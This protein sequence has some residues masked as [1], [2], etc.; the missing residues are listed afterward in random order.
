LNS[1]NSKQFIKIVSQ[2]SK[3]QYLQGRIEKSILLALWVD[4]AMALLERYMTTLN[5]LDQEIDSVKRGVLIEALEAYFMSSIILYHR[6]FVDQPSMHLEIKKVTQDVNLRK[7]YQEI[8]KLRNDEFIHWKGIRSAILVKYS[9]EP[10]SQVEVKFAENI[11]AQFKDS[12]GPGIDVI[13]FKNLYQETAKYIERK[14]IETL[15]TL[16]KCLGKEEVFEKCQFL[17]DINESVI[18]KAIK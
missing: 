17:N 8:E 3:V 10:V 2:D 6:C 15:D 16:R 12:I 5:H 7:T 1:A 9:F 14:R 13:P 11:H 18:Q 4:K